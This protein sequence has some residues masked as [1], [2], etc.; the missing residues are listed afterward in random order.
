[1]A[2]TNG[3]DGDDDGEWEEWEEDPGDSLTA[4]IEAYL[5]GCAPPPFFYKSFK[6]FIY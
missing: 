2:D 5:K 6:I 3:G 4:D 1:M